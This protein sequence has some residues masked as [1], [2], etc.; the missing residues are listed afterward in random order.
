MYEERQHVRIVA[1]WVSIAMLLLAGC[2]A[3]SSSDR[4]T[5]AETSATAD[6]A[7]DPYPAARNTPEDVEAARRVVASSLLKG[8]SADDLRHD[9]ATREVIPEEWWVLH[10]R[11]PHKVV[12]FTASPSADASAQAYVVTQAAKD[13]EWELLGA[14]EPAKQ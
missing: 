6:T 4:G 12:V 10:V 2:T 9:D 11:E 13:S 5:D 8:A 14:E 1:I 3:G 7:T